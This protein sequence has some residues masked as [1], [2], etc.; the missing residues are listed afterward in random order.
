MSNQLAIVNT[1]VT[2]TVTNL[3]SCG[4]FGQW[5]RGP[6][7]AHWL[8]SYLGGN[9]ERLLGLLLKRYQE[10]PSVDYLCGYETFK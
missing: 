7:A 9:F 10:Y 4:P 2:G 1:S 8:L 6:N 3:L 5:S